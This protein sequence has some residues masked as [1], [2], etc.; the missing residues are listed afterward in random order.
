MTESASLSRQEIRTTIAE[1]LRVWNEHDLD[2]VMDL[3][4]DEIVF[5]NWTGARVKGK[6]ALWRAWTPWFANHGGFR[7][8]EEETFIDEKQWDVEVTNYGEVF[9]NEPD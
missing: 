6:R 8:V 3:F 7:F 5:E 1:W 4:H 2:R 9:R